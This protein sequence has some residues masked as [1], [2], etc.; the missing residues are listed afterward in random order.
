MKKFYIFVGLAFVAGAMIASVITAMF[1]EGQK[2]RSVFRFNGSD[3]W[4]A[5]PYVAVNP[6]AEKSLTLYRQNDSCTVRID[7]R[8]GKA[9]ISKD[10]E[11][12]QKAVKQLGYKEMVALGVESLTMKTDTGGL[13][14][15]LHQFDEERGA[16]AIGRVA[17]NG[18]YI[19]ITANCEDET[20]LKPVREALGGVEYRPAIKN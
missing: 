20:G 12:R 15:E 14:Y 4:S 3:G 9:D 5:L 1:Y 6:D 17:M 16:L 8:S 11:A 13:S 19:E 18:K 2:P 7:E 10:I